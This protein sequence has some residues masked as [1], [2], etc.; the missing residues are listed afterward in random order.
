MKLD[1]VKAKAGRNMDTKDG[2]G[3]KRCSVYASAII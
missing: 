2:A 3:E 1:L